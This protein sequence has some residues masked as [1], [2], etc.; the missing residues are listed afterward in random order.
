M[1]T[2]LIV[3]AAFLAAASGFP[4]RTRARESRSV[5]W[6]VTTLLPGHAGA[7]DLRGGTFEFVTAEV[8]SARP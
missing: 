6:L 5:T 2:D 3:A 1:R 7:P 8:F 4:R